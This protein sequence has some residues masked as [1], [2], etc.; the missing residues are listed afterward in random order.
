M[1][2]CSLI[3]ELRLAMLTPYIKST[4]LVGF[5]SCELTADPDL[6]FLSRGC[7]GTL[8]PHFKLPSACKAVVCNA[9]GQPRGASSPRDLDLGAWA[10]ILEYRCCN[11]N[12]CQGLLRTGSKADRADAANG[13]STEYGFPEPFR[14]RWDFPKERRGSRKTHLISYI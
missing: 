13:A 10:D 12:A 4:D 8:L 2:A 1:F 3:S 14:H 7:R 11:L 6:S 5:A 9:G